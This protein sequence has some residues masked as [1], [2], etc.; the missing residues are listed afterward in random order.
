MPKQTT[1]RLPDDL[2]GKVEAVARA[3]GTSVNQLIIDS[4]VI[5]IDRVRKD[6]KFMNRVKQLAE[7]DR[8]ILDELTQ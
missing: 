4:L 7:R 1:V 6:T 2:A 3:K 8:E 5:E